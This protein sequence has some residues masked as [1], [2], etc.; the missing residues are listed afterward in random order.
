MMHEFAGDLDNLST[1][2]LC[3]NANLLMAWNFAEDHDEVAAK[4][5]CEALLGIT[6]HIERIANDMTNLAERIMKA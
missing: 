5:L 2:L 1:E 6:Q 4:P 3:V